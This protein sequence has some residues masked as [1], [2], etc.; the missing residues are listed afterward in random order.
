MKTRFGII[1][2]LAAA[3]SLP[4]PFHLC[5][6]GHGKLE[7]SRPATWWNEALPLGN[8][9]LGAMVFGNPVQEQL[10]LNEESIWSG[11]PNSNVNPKVEYTRYIP[12]VRDLIY[13]GEFQAATDL[14]TATVIPSESRGWNSGMEYQTF[15]SLRITY[16]DHGRY[17]D[18]HRELSLD[19][20]IAVTTYTA[21]GVRYRQEVF[22][23]FADNVVITRITADRKGAV[24]FVLSYTSPYIV[25]SRQQARGGYT[26]AETV[27][28]GSDMVFIGRSDDHEGVNGNVHFQGRTRVLL[29]GGRQAAT[30]GGMITVEDADA[31]TIYTS[32]ATNFVNW[33]DIGADPAARAREYLDAAVKKSYQ[34]AREDHIKI[35]KSYM[36]RVSLDLGGTPDG[37]DTDVRVADF[38]NTRDKDLVSTYFN[39]GRY[40]LICSSQPGGEPANLQGI[41]N[42]SLTP[43]W[44]SK[45]TTN[46]NLE[47]N[48]WLSES[49]NL[50]DL[51]QPLF[52]MIDELYESGKETA[53]IIYGV[54]GWI[55]HHNTDIWRVTGPTD[56]TTGLWMGGSG[57]MCRH[58]WEHYLYT[59]DREFLAHAYPI[60]RDAA[61]FYDQFMTYEPTHG[62]LVTCPSNSP[63]NSYTS[64]KGERAH[65]L[66]GPYMDTEIIMELWTSVI[67]SARLLGTDEDYAR[68]LEGRMKELA[69]LQIG[70]WN[71]LQEW[72]VDMDNPKDNHRHVSHLYALYPSNLISPYRTPQLTEAVKTSLVARGDAST[73]WSMGWKVCLWARLLDGDHAE[74]LIT[75]QLSLITRRSTGVGGTYPNLFD[76]HI[77]FQIDGNFGCT[78]GIAEM[79]LQSHD[80]FVNILPALPTNWKDGK[81]SGLMARG[82]FEVSIEWKD[83]KVSTIEVLSGNGGNLRLFSTTPLKA[84]GLRKAVG[85]NPNPLFTV[86]GVPET[87]VSEEATPGNF[88]APQGYFYDLATVP[89]Q[90]YTI[91]R[92]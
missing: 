92:K 80:G 65:L 61:I 18:Y 4:F 39:Y 44:D 24:N 38:A 57:W 21:D 88:N 42:D 11:Q 8:G 35:F 28:D 6:E 70:R 40:L 59:G 53:R 1:M 37:R 17:H 81:V 31:A 5:A 46:I 3:M 89:G 68:R 82:G 15:G 52:K 78:A 49:C 85:A 76:S 58:L 19:D 86:P 2:I 26:G 91:Y 48:Y 32:I 27:V 43:I 87:L 67:K 71:Q 45:Y 41:W 13:Q 23:S 51:G 55:L 63:E 14:A 84:K 64:P 12:Q 62:W 9:R 20:A 50:S 79:F 72:L 30:D 60:M 83:G 56:A 7:F 33:K 75:D 36:D 22:T 69:P 73:G 47:M 29:E 10:Q 54:D 66:S 16:P 77:P 90:T 25:A 74:K 34:Q